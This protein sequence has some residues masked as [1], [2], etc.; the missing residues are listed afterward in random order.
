MTLVEQVGS[1]L[2]A[3]GY[4]PGTPVIAAVSGGADSTALLHALYQLQVPLTVAHLNH[5]LRGNES[6]GDESFVRALA[7]RLNLP[8][9]GKSCDVKKLAEETG[10]SLEMAARQARLRFFA[11]IAGDNALVALAHNADDQVETFLLKLARGAGSDGLGGMP[12]LQPMENYSIIRPMLGISRATIFQWL[13]EHNLKWREDSSNH[14]KRFLRNCIRHEILPLLEKRLNPDIR[15]TILRTMDILREETRWMESMI[16]G[17]TFR[18]RLPIAARRRLLRKWLFEYNAE[19]VTF[20]AVDKILS[21][22]DGGKGTKVYELNSRQRVV[23]EYGQ[24]RFQYMDTGSPSPNPNPTGEI[25]PKQQNRD[26][27]NEQCPWRVFTETGTGWK[28]DHGKGAGILPAEAS[29]DAKKIGNATLTVRRFRPGDRMKPLGMTG[30]RK[31]QDIF[32]DQKIPRARRTE[33]PVVEC[34]GEI[35]WI[36]GYRTARG[37]EVPD[38]KAASVHIRIERI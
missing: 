19:N 18:D 35:I 33:I 29:F 27:E 13:K 28:K 10:W 22:I 30:S 37:W 21:L 2:R 4:Q 25:S 12:L 38:P 3:S 31:L 7:N 15:N 32:T 5:C 11:D 16:E 1:A 6:D 14:D 8:M 17:K 9:I 26:P 34:R 24:P 36:P 23:V 20:G